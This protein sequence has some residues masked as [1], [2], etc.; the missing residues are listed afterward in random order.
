M[1][2]RAQAVTDPAEA[3]EILNLLPKKYPEYTSPPVPMPK[4]NEIRVFRVTPRVISVL[5]YSRALVTRIS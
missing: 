3:N 5:D 2:A 1:A 4:V